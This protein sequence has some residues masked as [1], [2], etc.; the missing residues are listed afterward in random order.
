MFEVKIGVKH[1]VKAS[2]GDYDEIYYYEEEVE[3]LDEYN[4]LV[5]GLM[6][7]NS[8]LSDYNTD[9]VVSI[10]LSLPTLD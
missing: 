9:R 7:C 6:L 8:K 1:I 5:K 4:G 3:T 2:D 10:E